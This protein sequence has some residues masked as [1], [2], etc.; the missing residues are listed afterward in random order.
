MGTKISAINSL[1][2]IFGG[3]DVKKDSFDD[4]IYSLDVNTMSLHEHRTT[5]E[6]R[7][8]H[9]MHQISDKEVF[10]GFGFTGFGK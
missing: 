1:M 3:V 2:V 10:I 9:T 6:G 5:L 7:I 4:H 8:N